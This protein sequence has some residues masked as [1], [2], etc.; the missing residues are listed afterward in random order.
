MVG[1]L[2]TVV[3]VHT[4]VS[5]RLVGPCE[6]LERLQDVF[7]F[8]FVVSGIDRMEN[9][10]PGT[11]PRPQGYETSGGGQ[12]ADNFFHPKPRLKKSIQR[13]G[14]RSAKKLSIGAVV[15]TTV[16]LGIPM[17]LG[18]LWVNYV[19]RWEWVQRA[20]QAAKSIWT[21]RNEKDWDLFM[22][23]RKNAWWEMLGLKRYDIGSDENSSSDI[24]KYKR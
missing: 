1:L 13:S 18:P 22:T 23:Q 5:A 10:A 15:F 3:L 11:T 9:K 19:A 4:S 21:R 6:T 2:E 24:Q 17:I 20:Q 16:F 8:F 12:A 14:L 7:F